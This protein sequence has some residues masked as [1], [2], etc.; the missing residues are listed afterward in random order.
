MKCGRTPI[1]VV[2]YQGEGISWGRGRA[3]VIAPAHRVLNTERP[4]GEQPWTRDAVAALC[5]K[6]TVADLRDWS[7]R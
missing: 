3:A 4:A 7:F 1:F 5:Q 2:G 6:R